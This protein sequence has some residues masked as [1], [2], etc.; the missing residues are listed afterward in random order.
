[1]G[2]KLSLMSW[3]RVYSDKPPESRLEREGEGCKKSAGA[4]AIIRGP[5]LTVALP[6]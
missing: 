4:D 6:L 3:A 1:M 2:M 5:R